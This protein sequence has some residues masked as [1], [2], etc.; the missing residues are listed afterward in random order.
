MALAVADNASF[1][2]ARQQLYVA[3]QQ[4]AAR[5]RFALSEIQTYSYFRMA[6]DSGITQGTRLSFPKGLEA[7]REILELGI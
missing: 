6:G 1:T 4:S 5:S 2:R 3:S 7:F